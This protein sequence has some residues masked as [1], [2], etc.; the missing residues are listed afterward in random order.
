MRWLR[1]LGQISYNHYLFP[2][3]ST[4][5]VGE[6]VSRAF[7]TRNMLICRLSAFAFTLALSTVSWH[8]F[9]Q[10]ILRVK[11]RWFRYDGKPNIGTADV[12][13]QTAKHSRFDSKSLQFNKVSD[14]LPLAGEQ[15][16]AEESS[17]TST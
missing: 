8:F 2:L 16:V 12:D 3:Y 7:H 11:D 15:L 4:V 9:E 5:F 6:F 1:F 14:E 10:P 17:R 13:G